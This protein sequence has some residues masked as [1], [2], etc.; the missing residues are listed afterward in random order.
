L[1]AKSLKL[2]WLIK[3]KFIKKKIKVINIKIIDRR[4]IKII[5][6]IKKIKKIRRLKSW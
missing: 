3:S 1:D 2:R 6:K 4:V 5:K